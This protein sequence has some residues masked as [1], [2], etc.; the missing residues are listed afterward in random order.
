MWWVRVCVDVEW[1]DTHVAYFA[2]IPPPLEVRV[3][4][5]YHCVLQC[6]KCRTSLP[7]ARNV[8]DLL[9]IVAKGANTEVFATDGE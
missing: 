9:T 6:A 3:K 5:I 8:L 1:I 7:L 4:A 2:L